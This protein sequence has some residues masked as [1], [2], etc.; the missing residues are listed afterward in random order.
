MALFDFDG[1]LTRRDTLL[2][3]LKHCVGPAA[4]LRR[5]AGQAPGLLAMATGRRSNEAVKQQ[6]LRAF[7]D[8]WPI[9]K[10]AD[11]GARFAR[12]DVPKLLRTSS[13]QILEW[14]LEQGHTCYLVSAS[15]DVYVE[16]WGLGQ[17]FAGV[18]C[19]RL[20]VSEEGRLT[21]RLFGRNVY[22][23]EKVARIREALGLEP[24]SVVYAY[25]DSR[26]DWEMLELARHAWYRGRFLGST[27]PGWMSK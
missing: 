15:L 16:P 17:G 2:P 9:G 11:L 5:M 14:H 22:G 7:F 25:G 18:L 6:V 19:S 13:M 4:F 8:G 10:L 12:E 1:T 3:F 21:G 20:A 23:P 24:G 27:P 26:G